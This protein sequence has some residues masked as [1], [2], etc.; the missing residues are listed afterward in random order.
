M[1]TKLFSL[2]LRNFHENIINLFLKSTGYSSLNEYELETHNPVYELC[3]NNFSRH[4]EYDIGRL[5]SVDLTRYY[6]EY[7]PLHYLND[8]T[9]KFFYDNVFSVLGYMSFDHYLLK[10]GDITPHVLVFTPYRRLSKSV[11]LPLLE[12][13]SYFTYPIES[14]GKNTEETV[15]C[16]QQE[17]AE[18]SIVSLKDYYFKIYRNRVLLR[19]IDENLDRQL[20]P[21]CYEQGTWELLGFVST[22][23]KKEKAWILPIKLKNKL[24]A[25]GANYNSPVSQ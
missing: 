21:E 12:E 8:E 3:Y 16:P 9:K 13:F 25:A 5:P 6:A 11:K 4:F 7:V 23:S 19:A 10:F 2:T 22:Y 14:V 1:S 18:P 20:Y 24:I 15:V 17:V